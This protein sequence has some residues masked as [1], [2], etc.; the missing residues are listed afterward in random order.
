MRIV[1][2]FVK[3]CDNDRGISGAEVP[4]LLHL[5]ICILDKLRFL[6]GSVIDKTP[7][8]WEQFIIEVSCRTAFG[9][10]N[11]HR[12]GLAAVGA[13]KLPVVF[14]P[15]DLSKC[16]KLRSCFGQWYILI[17][18]HQIP[19]METFLAGFLLRPPVF[20]ENPFYLISFQQGQNFVHIAYTA[21][22]GRTCRTAF[23]QARLVKHL[24]YIFAEPDEKLPFDSSLSL[25]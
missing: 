18:F 3:H 11:A 1:H 22:C 19:Q 4:G 23:C 2:A 9:G 10:G 15:P 6:E 8:I 24:A 16:G 12:S 17:E 5:D 14:H 13:F 20:R 25:I 7:L 21:A